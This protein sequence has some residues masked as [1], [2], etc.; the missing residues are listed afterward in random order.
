[1]ANYAW[2]R[3]LHVTLISNKLGRSMTIGANKI[4]NPTITVEGHKYLSPLKD[5]CTIQIANLTYGEMVQIIDGQ[6]FDAYVR[7][8]YVNSVEMTIF[9]GGVLYITND[10]DDAETNIVTIL[11]ASQVV[12]RLSQSRLNLSL[13]SGINLYSAIKFLCDTSGIKNAHIDDALRATYLSDI[14][15]AND[16]TAGWLERLTTQFDGTYASTASLGGEDVSVMDVFKSKPRVIKLNERTISIAGGKPKLSSD[17]LKLEVMPTFEF[18]PGDVIQ[19]DNSIINMSN[20][21]AYT[22]LGVQLDQD[23]Q[24]MIF[25]INYRLENRGSSFMLELLCKARQLFKT[26]IDG[27]QV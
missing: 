23:G 14:I 16:N 6:Y 24:Y 2:I 26:F 12:A 15:S 8:G 4:M 20:A 11:C 17:G 21:T 3:V 18:V 5:T 9:K 25:E 19:I 13:N 27:V 22:N 1:M 7:C 10:N